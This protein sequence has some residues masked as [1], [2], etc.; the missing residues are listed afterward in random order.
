MQDLGFRIL[1]Q[2]DQESHILI[3]VEYPDS[4]RF[5]FDAV[6]DALYKCGFTIYPG[7]IGKKDAFRLANMGAITEK[8][9][10]N[11]LQS[12][13]QVL[14]ELN[15]HIQERENVQSYEQEL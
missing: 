15:I 12:L 11:F 5:N 1:T 3:T 6:H 8:D 7:K 10:Q 9:I 4:P 2:P 14:T 13:Q